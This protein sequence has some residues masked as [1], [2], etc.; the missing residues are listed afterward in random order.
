V[1]GC[2]IVGVGVLLLASSSANGF[3]LEV[4]RATLRGI[5]GVHVLVE[6]NIDTHAQQAGL[7]Q[8]QRQ[9]AVELR[10]R[11]AGIR[12]VTQEQSRSMPGR[13]WLYVAVA[14][15]KSPPIDVW[16]FTIYVEVRQMVSL[17]RAPEIVI[18]GSTW[19]ASAGLYTVHTS[20]LQQTVRE[21][22]A[23]VIDVF[24]NAYLAVNPEQAGRPPPPNPASPRSK[25]R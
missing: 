9:T 12:V 15:L 22:L 1:V 20:M 2:L 8:N 3:D 25:R 18:P 11:K 16:A 7:T 13:P 4:T 21:R 17:T 10:L 23:D 24:I 19:A 6:G 14:V 5:E